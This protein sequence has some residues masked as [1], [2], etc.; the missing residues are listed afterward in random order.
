MALEIVEYKGWSQN[1][2]LANAEVE[3]IVTKDVGPRVIRFG[4]I[5]ERN[6]FGQIPDQLGGTGEDEWQIRGGHR[7]WIAPEDIPWSYELDNAPVEIEETGPNAITTHQPA[8]PITGLAKSMHISLA[9][10]ANTVTLKHS[11]TNES[12]QPVTLAAWAISVLATGGLAIVPL[13][14]KI[15]HTE[16][17]THN[18]EWSLWAYTD[19]TDP[20]WTLGARYLTLRHDPERGPTKLGIVQREGWAG[21]LLDG[22]FFRKTVAWQP[23][24]A[25]PDGGVNLETFANETFLE[26]ETLGP[27]TTLQPAETVAHEET[28]TLHKGIPDCRTEAEFDEHLRLT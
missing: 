6:I 11:L 23:D 10:S 7:L 26:L 8:G 2:R 21:Y 28:W 3:L 1:V 4:F 17:V 22:F 19:F 5:G 12:D 15:P 18:Q 20:R 9:P 14:P 25:Y 24:A 13:P 16:R 27:L